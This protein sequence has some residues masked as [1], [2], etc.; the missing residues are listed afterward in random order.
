MISEL[1]IWR[2]ANLLIREHGA[3]AASEALRRAGQLL[4]RGDRDGW[5]LWARIRLAIE[6]LQAPG[7]GELH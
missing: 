2:A 1:D 3:G 7:R 4:D 5:Q 6:A